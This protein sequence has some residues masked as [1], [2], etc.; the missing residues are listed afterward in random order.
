MSHELRSHPEPPGALDATGDAQVDGNRESRPFRFT[1]RA[2]EY[3]RIWIVNVC[4][5]V[6]TLGLYGPWAKVRN[7]RYFYGNLELEGSVFQYDADP[8][9][10]LIGRL[11]VMGAFFVIAITDEFA[12]VTSGA[13]AIAFAFLFPWMVVCS[14]AFHHRHSL[15]RGVRFRF[16]RSYGE[17]AV[18]FIGWPIVVALTMGLLYPWW[19]GHR[20]QFLAGNSRFGGTRFEFD[21]KAGGYYAAYALAGLMVIV[22]VIACS[23]L[24]VA[25]LLLHS[26]GVDPAEVRGSEWL[27]KSGLPPDAVSVT[28]MLALGGSVGLLVGYAIVQARLT[29]LLYLQAALG[30]FRFR[31]DVR[32]L[33]LLWI[34]LSSGVAI[35]ASVGLLYPWTK[36]RMARYRANHLVLVGDGDLDAFV[37]G[38]EQEAS[39]LGE[40]ADEAADAFDF[41]FGL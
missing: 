28:T 13:L 15:Y 1:G 10:I 14:T 30:K 20:Q 36:V 35:A 6:V 23:F 12:P 19:R 21:L 32:A 11:I 26:L 24:G 4:L 33:G 18:I 34:Y 25:D 8:T 39:R 5:S 2:G 3:F 29:N 7:R 41:D 9:R 31:S 17:A 22:A 16:S 27:R 40:V 38:S 37:Q